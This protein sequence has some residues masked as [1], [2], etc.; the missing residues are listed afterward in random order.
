MSEAEGRET[1]DDPE[2][3]SEEDTISERSIGFCH[4]LGVRAFKSD[5]AAVPLNFLQTP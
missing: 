5:S 2:E 3:Q 1:S 4:R